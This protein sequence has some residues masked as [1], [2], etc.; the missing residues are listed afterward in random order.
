MKKYPNLWIE[1]GDIPE[2]PFDNL[3]FILVCKLLD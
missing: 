1:P 2:I 3:V